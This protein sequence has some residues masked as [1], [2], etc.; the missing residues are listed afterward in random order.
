MIKERE[1]VLFEPLAVE[2]TDLTRLKHLIVYL[3]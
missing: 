2:R 3:S 1:L